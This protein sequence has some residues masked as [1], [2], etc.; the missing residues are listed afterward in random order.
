MPVPDRRDPVGQ[1]ERTTLEVLL[2]APSLVP[3]DADDLGA[4]AFA[5]P[6]YRA[7]HEAVMAAGGPAEG[8]RL[9]AEGGNATA[10][11]GRVLEEA[12]EPVRPLVTELAVAPLPEDRPDALGD[13]VRGVVRR[14][15]EIGLTRRIAEVRGRLQRMPED[16]AAYGAT[17]AELVGLEGRR[18]TLRESA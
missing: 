5:A 7:V 17:F 2:Q 1:V 16:D 14:L 13:Y 4:D 11:V 12:A 10:W 3:L 18:R 6:A 15:L 9:V 8:R